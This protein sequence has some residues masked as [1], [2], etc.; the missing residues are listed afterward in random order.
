VDSTVEIRYAGVVMGRSTSLRDHDDAGAFVG[1][2]EPL[3]VGTPL[4]IKIGD[5]VREA[6]V[7]DV[8]ESADPAAAGM[9]IRYASHAGA[10][11]GAAGPDGTPENLGDETSEAIAAGQGANQAEAGGGGGRRR[12]K[13]R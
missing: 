6:R 4:T 13:R 8:I 9:R 3:P 12:R 1:F 7:E 11:N 2:S 5:T 10:G